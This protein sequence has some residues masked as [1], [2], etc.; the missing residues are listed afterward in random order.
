MFAHHPNADE[1]CVTVSDTRADI[2]VA[3]L[4]VRHAAFFATAACCLGL[5]KTHKPE[6]SRGMLLALRRVA[7]SPRL[8]I[9]PPARTFKAKSKKD[10]DPAATATQGRDP[11]ALFKQAIVS[12]PPDPDA[13]AAAV[14]PH[15][16][17]REH[18]AAYSRAKMIE[19]H[20]VGKHFTHMIR[21]RKAALD[22]LPDEL[23]KEASLPDLE[24]AP[25]E[26][27]IF[28]E[29]APIPGFQTKLVTT[30]VE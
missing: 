19:H 12:Q 6:T 5:P 29:T 21:L 3:L 20:R 4:A 7:A 9:S 14:L 26:R 13:V 16:E 18:R 23:R 25:I 22:A 28:T 1:R 27:R 2:S 8:R 10:A 15:D 11:Y 24:L 30:Q 17:W